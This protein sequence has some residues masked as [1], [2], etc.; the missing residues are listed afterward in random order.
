MSGREAAPF[1]GRA[2][3]AALPFLFEMGGR[4]MDDQVRID[5]SEQVKAVAFDQVKAAA[6]D[7]QRAAGPFLE[8]RGLCGA[9]AFRN[10]SFTAECGETLLLSADVQTDY[11]LNEALMLRTDPPAGEIRIG[12]RRVT[13]QSDERWLIQR[14]PSQEFYTRTYPGAVVGEKVAFEAGLRET[15][16]GDGP[17]APD[18]RQC[19]EQMGVAGLEHARYGALEPAERVCAMIAER[20]L[21]WDAAVILLD[22][23]FDGL[24]EAEA[25]TIFMRLR[26]S[27]EARRRERGLGWCVLLL[28]RPGREHPASVSLA[29]RR[30]RIAPDGLESM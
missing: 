7:Q 24:T 9:V 1:A 12:G 19:L 4:G 15:F 11:A 27:L 6:P 26:N 25:R 18:A 28:E 23:A 21:A 30:F 14:V 2:I 13:A 10:V 8:V 5:A 20:A 17:G 29:D 3:W 22:G 16:L